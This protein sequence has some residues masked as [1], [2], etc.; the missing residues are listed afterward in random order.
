MKS[1]IVGAEYLSFEQRCPIILPKKHHVTKLIIHAYHHKYLHQNHS[2]VLN[3]LGQRFMIPAL[4]ATLKSVRAN[5]WKCR[6]LSIRPEV[7]EM[8]SLPKARMAVWTRPFTYTGI[9]YFGP[10]MVRH[11]R[12]A[13]K[14]WAAIFTCMTTRA[15][16]LEVASSLSSDA[17]LLILRCFIA[18]RGMPAEIFCDNGTNFHGAESELRRIAEQNC[19]TAMDGKYATIK[20]NFN[21]PCAPHMGGAWERLIR[22]VKSALTWM[23]TERVPTD[24]LM[25]A[26]LA[27]CEMMVNSRPLT[28]VDTGDGNLESLTPN[29]FLLG[30]SSGVKPV[31]D[32]TDDPE[33][34]KLEWKRQQQVTAIFWKRFTAEYLPA[35]SQRTKWYDRVDPI[36]VGDVVAIVDANLPGSWQLGRIIKIVPSKDGSVRQAE[37]KTANGVF[38]RPASK[39]AVLIREELRDKDVSS[40]GGDIVNGTWTKVPE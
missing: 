21:P 40:A 15:V 29:H 9:D 39:L 13:E 36:S 28:Y 18:R 35:I 4:R 24:E 22:A 26:I 5:C 8:S 27:E 6:R 19:R 31:G 1:R 14:K 32:M 2:I 17:F 20:W 23:K 11:G 7:P 38:K 10:F 34:L 33:V 25:R 3:E 30:S 37:V 16:H 12:R